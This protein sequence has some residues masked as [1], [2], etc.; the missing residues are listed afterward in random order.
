MAEKNTGGHGFKGHISG[1]TLDYFKKKLDCK[2]FLD[3][4]SGVGYNVAF[5]NEQFDYEAYGIEGDEDCL[6]DPVCKNLYKHD[7][8]NDGIVKITEIPNEVDLIWSVSVSE[9]IDESKVD[10]YMNI[11]TR[12][13]YVIFTWCPIGWPG[14]HHVNCQEAHYWIDK[15]KNIGYMLDDQLTKIVR[16]NSNLVM[17]K[18]AYW[19]DPTLNQK[20]VPKMYLRNW[21]L[22]F[23]TN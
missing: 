16:Q 22:C 23:K 6:I 4:G 17:C 9:H 11:F 15:F 18:S 12:A 14:V 8:E 20:K 19:R 5:A 13:K 10:N 21:G 2:T 7:F 1:V 3:V